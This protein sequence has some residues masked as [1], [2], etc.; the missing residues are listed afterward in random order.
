MDNPE[1]R[2]RTAHDDEMADEAGENLGRSGAA[3]IWA[4]IAG[5]VIAVVALMLWLGEARGHEA[6]KG[7][8]YPF[9]CC[10]DYDCR[11]VSSGRNGIVSERPE[12]FVINLTG[13][14]VPYSDKRVRPSPDGEFHWCSKAGADDGET[15]CLFVPPRGF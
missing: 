9:S 1:T 14:V 12:G 5:C 3:I 4:V 6:A 10:S 8:S 7:W 2:Y 13:E 15:I 11:A